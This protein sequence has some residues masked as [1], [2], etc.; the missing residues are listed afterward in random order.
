[1]TYLADNNIC[2]MCRQPYDSVTMIPKEEIDKIIKDAKE[3]KTG[4]EQ[5]DNKEKNNND[6]E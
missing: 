3:T 5:E 2:F 4:D 6:S 1:M